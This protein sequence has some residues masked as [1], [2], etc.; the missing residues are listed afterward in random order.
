MKRKRSRIS[1]CSKYGNDKIG[2]KIAIN[3]KESAV[4]KKIDQIKGYVKSK[5]LHDQDAKEEF[6]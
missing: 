1:S 5:N 6:K 4:D 2:D 3:S